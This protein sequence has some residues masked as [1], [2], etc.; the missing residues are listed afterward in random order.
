MEYKF[1]TTKVRGL[2]P[3]PHDASYFNWADISDMLTRY[4]MDGWRVAHM[5]TV[6]VS[7]DTVLCAFTLERA[8]VPLPT[9]KPR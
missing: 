1:V 3:S 8:V 7:E 5:N 6:Q 2:S 4:G 9:R